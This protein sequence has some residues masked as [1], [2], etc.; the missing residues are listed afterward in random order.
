MAPRPKEDS[1]GWAAIVARAL[2]LVSSVPP[3]GSVSAAACRRGGVPRWLAA[4]RRGWGA[5]ASP[6]SAT[7]A[8]CAV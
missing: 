8:P 3:K 7:V 6:L 5:V 1:A 2:A 4:L